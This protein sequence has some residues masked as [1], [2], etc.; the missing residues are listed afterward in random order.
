M[1]LILLLVYFLGVIFDPEDGSDMSLR[2][3]QAFSAL[4]RI[5][6][7]KTYCI[8]ASCYTRF[9]LNRVHKQHGRH[10]DNT[11]ILTNNKHISRSTWLATSHRQKLA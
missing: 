4:L 9:T 1:I 7:Q 3:G 2:N 8:L 6:T 10:K 11:T 5:T